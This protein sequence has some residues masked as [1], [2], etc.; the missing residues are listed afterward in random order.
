MKLRNMAD[1]ASGVYVYRL[2]AAD[3]VQAKMTAVIK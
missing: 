2:R 3:G 1:V